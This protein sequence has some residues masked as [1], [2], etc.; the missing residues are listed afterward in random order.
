[1]E[2]VH[3]VEIECCC[4]KMAQLV[5]SNVEG[6]DFQMRPVGSRV[7]V[8]VE[9]KPVIRAIVTMTPKVAGETVDACPFCLTQF[10]RTEIDLDTGL[11]V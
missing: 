11:P 2:L 10:V 9:D 5:A 3:K 8:V 4:A 1:M 6:G 7:V